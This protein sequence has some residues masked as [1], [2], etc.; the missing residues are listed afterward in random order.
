VRRGLGQVPGIRRSLCRR[1]LQE[2]EVGGAAVA[3]KPASLLQLR[4]RAGGLHVADLQVV[5]QV[6]VGVLVVVA[7]GQLPNC[8]QK[9][10][11][12]V[13]SLPGAQ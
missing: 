4:Q 2:I 8:W 11:P 10:L 3:M 9:R 1:F 7:V 13:L 5:A 12:Q 6:A